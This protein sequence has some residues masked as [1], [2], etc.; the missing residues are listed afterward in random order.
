MPLNYG[1]LESF[2]LDID[3]VSK[4]IAGNSLRAYL[5]TMFPSEFEYYLVTLERINRAGTVHEQL[6]FPVSPQSISESRTSLVNIKKTNNSIVALTNRTFAPTTISLSGTFGKKIRILLTAEKQNTGAAFQFGINLGKEKVP[7]KRPFKQYGEVHTGFG[8]T[9]MLEQMVINSQKY[10]DSL[11]FLYNYI[12][13]N[14]YLVECT[15][16]QFTQS[17]ENNMFWNYSLSFK[18]L[19]YAKDVYPGGSFAYDKTMRQQLTL[20]ILNRGTFEILRALGGLQ[21]VYNE[22]LTKIGIKL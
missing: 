12:S 2:G 11:L 20:G 9:K 5:T 7:Y 14:H 4:Q 13:G 19:A 22:G 21:S 6:I 10:S 1:S 15:D 8:V 17:M 3:R 18:S 16:M